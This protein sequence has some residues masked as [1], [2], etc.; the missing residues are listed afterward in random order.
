MAP[1]RCSQ[2]PLAAHCDHW[3]GLL[4][5]VAAEAD[6]QSPEVLAAKPRH[7]LRRVIDPPPPVAGQIG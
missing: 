7:K 3:R 2:L 1:Y 6:D 4:Y 5:P